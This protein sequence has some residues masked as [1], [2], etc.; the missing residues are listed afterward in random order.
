MTSCRGKGYYSQRIGNNHDR[1]AVAVLVAIYC[2]PENGEMPSG[3]KNKIHFT[4]G[5]NGLLLLHAVQTL[6]CVPFSTSSSAFSLLS[7][8][9]LVLLLLVSLVLL[10]VRARV[11]EHNSLWLVILLSSSVSACSRSDTYMWPDLRELTSSETEI[12]V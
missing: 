7:A 1:Y 9:V 2:G 11:H 3:S 10:T 12:L 5:Y 8:E 6:H 4:V